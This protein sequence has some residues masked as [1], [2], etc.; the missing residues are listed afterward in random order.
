MRTRLK[1][2]VRKLAAPRPELALKPRWRE[3]TTPPATRDRGHQRVIPPHLGEAEHA[4]L[5]GQIVVSAMVES[6]SIVTR[7]S[8]GAAPAAQARPSS[9][10]ATLSSRRA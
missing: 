3:C 5:L 10:P 9:S 1:L 4:A 2:S 7:A 8:P 6:T